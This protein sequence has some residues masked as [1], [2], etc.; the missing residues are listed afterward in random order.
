VQCFN[1]CPLCDSSEVR[2]C[3][4]TVPESSPLPIAAS[5][6][7]CKQTSTRSEGTIRAG[8]ISNWFLSL[9]HV[10]HWSYRTAKI[11]WI[12]A[13][14]GFVSV[15]FKLFLLLCNSLPIVGR[16]LEHNLLSLYILYR[17]SSTFAQIALDNYIVVPPGAGHVW[18]FSIIFTT[19][20][21]YLS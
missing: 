9:V 20:F 15:S 10:K 4:F 3:S 18:I 13:V 1:A 21:R 17:W 16:C 8:V 5:A 14:P 11:L 19:L 6:C 7:K 12:F 2:H